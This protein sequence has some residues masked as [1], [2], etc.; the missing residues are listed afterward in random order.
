MQKSRTKSEVKR[1]QIL[2]AATLQ[3]TQHGY[4]ATNMAEIAKQAGVSK[5]T[6][7]S[8]F[9]NKDE[10]FITAISYKC[11]QLGIDD[12]LPENLGPAEQTL[13]SFAQRFF[14]MITSSDSMA[15]HRTCAAESIA[16]PHL[17]Q[18]FFEA[19]PIFIINKLATCLAEY[20]RRGELDIDDCRSAAIQFLSLIKGEQWTR[21]EFNIA[22][23]LSEQEVDD[24]L[25]HSVRLFV[26]GYQYID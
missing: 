6:V 11:E 13:C 10:L 20:H 16:H 18:L 4:A 21:L 22:A 12:L 26:R 7:Y 5:Q 2:D 25:R 1:N 23:S 9:G 14:A 24:Y 3:F 17:S 8:H 15:I 19:G